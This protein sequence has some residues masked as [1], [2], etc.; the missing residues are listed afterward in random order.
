M[1]YNF[2]FRAI[3]SRLASV[4]M[5]CY[6]F[7]AVHV[8]S[9]QTTGGVPTTQYDALVTFYNS[10]GGPNWSFNSNWLSSEPVENWFGVVVSNGNVVGLNLSINNLVGSVPVSTANLPLTDLFLDNNNLTSIS[11]LPN[12]LVNLFINSNQI[13]SLTNLPTSLQILN[14]ASNKLST[15]ASFPNGIIGV[16]V[17]SNELTKLPA[18]P[19]SLV[20]LVC[21]NNKITSL[22]APLSASLDFLDCSNN[23]LTLLPAL[24]ANLTSLI[25]SNNKLTSLPSF[26]SQLSLINVSNNKINVLPALPPFVTDLRIDFNN[27]SAIP[28]LP[29]VPNLFISVS[30]NRL[31]F[32][33]LEPI[34]GR[35]AVPRLYSPQANVGPTYSIILASAGVTLN[36]N[37][38]YAGNTPTTRYVW[39]KNDTLRVSDTLSVPTLKI[40]NAQVANSGSYTTK[41]SSSKV[42]GLILTRNPIKVKIFNFSS[43]TSKVSDMVVYPNPVV[44]SLQITQPKGWA[45]KVSVSIT[46]EKTGVEVYNGIY[47]FENILDVA[48]IASG[49][50]VLKISD[51]TKH[52][53][54]H[55][56][57]D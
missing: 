28:A 17:S 47:S 7:L 30:N 1:Y 55:I 12:S 31:S 26:P 43:S 56:I 20:S 22:P 14:A 27:I 25:A 36:L 51:G 50:Y 57:K 5:F 41:I 16:N 10:T 42:P 2:N 29:S 37:A 18:L 8:A 6:L 3:A 40:V 23:L 13:V 32:E 54:V 11:Q 46:S 33:D 48:N 45:D 35:F 49:N 53:S 19:A 38:N 21:S 9:A 24:S 4:A 39:F 34:I 15:I 44:N 52:K